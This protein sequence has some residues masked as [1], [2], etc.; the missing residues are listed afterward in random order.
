MALAG[1]RCSYNVA[2]EREPVLVG[3]RVKELRTRKRMSQ[4]TVGQAAGLSQVAISDIELGK[5]I[6][7]DADKVAYIADALGTTME[8]LLDLTDDPLPPH[9]ARAIAVEEAVRQVLMLPAS[10]RD[11]LVEFLRLSQ[12]GVHSEPE[13]ADTD[14]GG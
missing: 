9:G 8:Y 11:A 5:T 13:T 2:M 14:S 12:T 1:H 6:R 3:E 7:V 10:A 4:K